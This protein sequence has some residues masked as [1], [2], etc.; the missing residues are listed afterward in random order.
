MTEERVE[1]HLHTVFSTMDAV[2][3]VGE[4]IKKAADY[5]HTAVAVTDYGCIQAFPE[6]FRAANKY[7][8]KVIYGMECDSFDDNSAQGE[9]NLFRVILLAKSSEGIRNLYSLISHRENQRLCIP[10]SLLQN[11]REGL[12]IGAA[13]YHGEL[14]QAVVKTNSTV[15]EVEPKLRAI[16]EFYDYIEIHPTLEEVKAFG[17]K[18]DR[19]AQRTYNIQMARVARVSDKP[20]VAV[21]NVHFL[22]AEDEI[23]KKILLSAKGIEAGSSSFPLYFKSTQEMLNEFSYLGNEEAL[24]AVV[25]HSRHIADLVEDT[26]SPLPPY[27]CGLSL[28]GAGED[29][30]NKCLTKAQMIYGFP[31]PEPVQT[32][33]DWELAAICNHHFPA[34]YS[35]AE[36]MVQCAKKAGFP[37]STRGG[38]PASLVAFLLGITEINPLPAHYVCPKCRHGIFGVDESCDNGFDLPDKACPNC[39]TLMKKDGFNLSAETFMGL[40]G[41]MVPCIDLSFAE[42]YR[43]EAVNQLRELFG[44]ECVF[45]ADTVRTLPQSVASEYVQRYSQDCGL[46]LSSSEQTRICRKLI[47]V[48]QSDTPYT[49]GYFIAPKGSNIASFLPVGKDGRDCVVHFPAFEV[50]NFLERFDL[51][52][53]EVLSVFR[54]LQL[55]TG[56]SPESIPLDDEKALKMLIGGN[57]AGIPG[58]ESSLMQSMIRKSNPADM[59][60]LIKLVGLF[61]GSGTWE[62]NA[63]TLLKSGETPLSDVIALRD[64][65]MQLLIKHGMSRADSYKYMRLIRMGRLCAGCGDREWVSV[66]KLYGIADRYIDSVKKIRYL[67]SK[68]HAA[69]YV[70]QAFRLAW[71]KAYYP[72]QFYSVMKNHADAMG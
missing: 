63:E 61:L 65:V 45:L 18:L 40:Y 66:F 33:L 24:D 1:L 16:S 29:V 13:G 20:L 4:A 54:E 19:H 32:R 5:G 28:E 67:F 72:E 15:F 23:C 35:A 62:E 52:E 38:V 6:A 41:E 56:F 8:V 68:A 55:A 30:R 42:E 47:K 36:R 2:T 14:F 49:D 69:T 44:K 48:K 22:E 43:A 70:V 21:G 53:C 60:D 50:G 39:G 31:L 59:A 3:E 7:G 71:Y 58:F 17:R 9:T 64:D 10:K 27:S 25:Y 51:L 37:V 46:C 34:F 26:V 11:H 12:L 57:T